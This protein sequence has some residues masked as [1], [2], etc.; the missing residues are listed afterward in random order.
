MPRTAR[1]LRQ[2]CTALVAGSLVSCVSSRH[3]SP[4]PPP[5]AL[6][7]PPPPAEPRLAYVESIVGPADIGQGPSLWSQVSVWFSGKSAQ[8][9]HLL[10]PFGVALDEN[11]NLCLTDTGAGTVCYCDFARKHWRR[12][13]SIG[14][15]RLLSPVAV[16]RQNGIFYVADSELGK[17]FAFGDDGREV[18]EISAPLERPA[19]LAIAPGTLYVADSQTH[20]VLAFDLHG[21]LRFQFGHRGS[22]PG[23]FNFPS[24]LSCDATGSLYV[25]DSMNARIQVFDAQGKFLRVIGSAGDTSGHFGRPKG[26]ATDGAGRLYV[27]DALYDNLQIFD[28]DG[29]LLLNLGQAGSAPGEFWLPN[30]IAIGAT[31]RIFVTDTF[32]HRVQVFDYIGKP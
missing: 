1:S 21:Q 20:Q 11:G 31:N 7:W 10:K 24:H 2:L 12:W 26:V 9:E 23:E 15:T 25:T 13:D 4:N 8:R 30:G 18:F 32:N 6:V 14:K 5:A 28:R 17:V 16:A 19:G 22:A 3:G 27:V 29:R